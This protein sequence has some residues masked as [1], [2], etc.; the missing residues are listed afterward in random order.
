MPLNLSWV[1]HD[2]QGRYLRLRDVNLGPV[3][4]EGVYMIWHGG[5]APRVVRVGQG[6]IADRLAV[7]RLDP[8]VQ[9]YSGFVLFVTWAVVSAGQRDGVERYLADRWKPLVGDAWPAVAPIEV[10]SPWS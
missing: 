8:D 5:T 7:H 9:Y 4:D 6:I 3:T 2:T 10:N 1:S